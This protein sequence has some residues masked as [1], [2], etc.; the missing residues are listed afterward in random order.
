M[1]HST[2]A[3]SGAGNDSAAPVVDGRASKNN[4]GDSSALDS[5][6]VAAQRPGMAGEGEGASQKTEQ[7]Q[8]PSPSDWP[9]DWR[10]RIAGDDRKALEQLKR[11]GSPADIWKKARSLE[12]KLS[13]GEYRRDLPKEASPEQLAAWRIER[14]IPEAASDYSIE[15][16]DGVVPGEADNP[17]IDAFKQHAHAR[18]WDNAKVNEALGWY[19]AEQERQQASRAEADAAFRQT[20]ETELR[21][22]FGPQLTPNLNAVK[23]LV[24]AMPQGVAENFLAGR[25]ADGTRIGDNPRIIAWLAGLSR[26]LNPA[27][28]LV[29]AGAGSGRG[30]AERI[31]EIETL[32]GDRMSD[33]WRGPKA[34]AMQQEYRDLI[35]A[36]DRRR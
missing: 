22:T 5:G 1:T 6:F 14:G 27:A 26:E 25:L 23:N 17:V 2:S 10:E 16:P 31:R 13:S 3:S 30:G 11:A 4:A 19:Y 33:Y 28:T 15:L 12:Q 21:E 32:M 18:N 9:A 34:D 29:P 20:A 8:Q 35:E 24:A 7:S 36:R